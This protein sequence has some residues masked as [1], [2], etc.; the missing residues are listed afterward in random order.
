MD[1]DHLFPALPKFVLINS[2]YIPQDNEDDET[3]LEEQATCGENDPAYTRCRELLEGRRYV[4]RLMRFAD[5]RQPELPTG[6]V[7]P[8]DQLTSTVISDKALSH[9]CYNRVVLLGLLHLPN[10]QH[11]SGS[12]GAYNNLIHTLNE[13][14]IKAKEYELERVSGEYQLRP[15]FQWLEQFRRSVDECLDM[16]VAAYRFGKGHF[17]DAGQVLRLIEQAV[18]RFPPMTRLLMD[19]LFTDCDFEKEYAVDHIC[20]IRIEKRIRV[21]DRE[22]ANG[23]S[24]NDNRGVVVDRISELKHHM[25]TYSIRMRGLFAHRYLVDWGHGRPWKKLYLVVDS[26]GPE[27]IPVSIINEFLKFTTLTTPLASKIFSVHPIPSHEINEEDLCVI[28]QER[29]EADDLLMELRNCP[30]RMHAGCVIEYW[31]R[32]HYYD[33]DCPVCR[34]SSESIK[35]F[36]PHFPIRTADVCYHADA[37]ASYDQMRRDHFIRHR[38]RRD[39]PVEDWEEHL[40]EHFWERESIAWLEGCTVEERLQMPDFFPSRRVEWDE[41]SA[42]SD[43]ECDMEDPQEDEDRDENADEEDAQGNDDQDPGDARDEPEDG[44]EGEESS[45]TLGSPLRILTSLLDWVLIFLLVLSF[46]KIVGWMV[47]MLWPF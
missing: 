20:D 6:T 35:E 13:G 31:D 45:S 46:A 24:L 14:P 42:S 21:L 27:N 38:M 1:V 3:W 33:N 23:R 25:K 2:Y 18:M 28:C 4:D 32:Y 12:M 17:S 44:D 15:E 34:T 10:L 40:Q 16:L 26:E 47:W 39:I 7:V 41:S 5:K 36:F 30:H 43:G 37:H 11:P 22:S 29:Y 9:M 8:D 19:L